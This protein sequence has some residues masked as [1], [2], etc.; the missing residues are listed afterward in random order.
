M[1]LELEAAVAAV[2][3]EGEPYEART[4]TIRGVDF[5][6]FA[7]APRN[8][9]DLYESGLNHADEDFYV[10]QDERYTYQDM[11]CGPRSAVR[12][13]VAGPRHRARRPGRHCPA[14]LS[15]VDCRVHGDHLV[16]ARSPWP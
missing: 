3:A 4:E 13:R 8:L 14:Q 5:T 12:Q 15:R 2:T 11:T 9:R 1:Q 7:N 16:R 10:Y 6:I